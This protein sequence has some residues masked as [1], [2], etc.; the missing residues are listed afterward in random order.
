MSARILLLIGDIQ[1]KRDDFMSAL[2]SY[3]QIPVFYGAQGHLMPVAELGA[4]RSL[5]GIKIR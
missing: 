4:S 5:F 2:D 1:I 3:L